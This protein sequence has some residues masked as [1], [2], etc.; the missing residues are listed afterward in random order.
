MSEIAYLN[1]TGRNALAVAEAALAPVQLSDF[2]KLPQA[3][4]EVALARHWA[5]K[6]VDSIAAQ[7]GSRSKAI[8]LFRA[9]VEAKAFTPAELEM[10][11]RLQAKQISKPTLDRWAKL[12]RQGGVAALANGQTGRR[13]KRDYLPLL[14]QWLQMPPLRK[15][16]TYAEKLRD[17]GYDVTARQVQLTIKKLPAHLTTTGNAQVGK[18]YRLQNLV[19]YVRRD[20]SK[21]PAGLVWQGD[22]HLLDWYT[23]HHGNGKPHRYEYTQWTDLGSDIVVG[24][25]LSDAESGRSTYFSICHAVLTHDHVPMLFHVDPGPGFKARMITGEVTG[26]AD[27]LGAEFSFAKVGNA[28]GKGVT[29]GSFRWLEEKV[30][31]DFGLAYCGHDMPAEIVRTQEA[32][33]AKGII[34]VPSLAETVAA[35]TAYHLKRAHRPCP[36][37][38]PTKTRLELWQ[39]R[40]RN[41]LHLPPEMLAR[42]VEIVVVRNFTIR[43]FNRFYKHAELNGWHGR[44]VQAAY[45]I[46]DHRSIT[47]RTLDG[48]WLC[49]ALLIEAVPGIS[50]SRLQDLEQKRLEGQAKRLAIKQAENADKARRVIDHSAWEAGQA[51]LSYAADGAPMLRD[52]V[53]PALTQIP[54]HRLGREQGPV[55]EA[56]FASVSAA[57][58]DAAA[59]STES[60]GERFGRALELRRARNAGEAIAEADALWL[61]RY[62]TSAECEA[63]T[64]L[65]EAFG[66]VPGLPANHHKE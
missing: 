54:R 50:E 40:E 46:H 39:G 1:P 38:H 10:L 19:A 5:L 37:L 44:E 18:N 4:R 12:L 53:M 9:R 2:A 24:W 30:G 59:E 61:S 27:R 66:T 36:A 56:E 57:M 33:M 34:P 14:V 29:E 26:L 64:E 6:T 55:D 32:K 52:V 41:P 13:A 21:I 49:E 65:Y 17:A 20:R 7:C 51:S 31:K 35:I 63:L 28:K 25:W 23:R 43:L 8:Q 58:A 60:S 62:S 11:S 22:G 47:V 42:P 15:A 48:R 45:N 16:S 3:K